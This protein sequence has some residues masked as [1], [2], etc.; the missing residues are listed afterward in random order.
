MDYDYAVNDYYGNEQTRQ[1]HV[2]PGK[3]VGHWTA[4]MADGAMQSVTYEAND[5]GYQANV[6]ISK[7][8]YSASANSAPVQAYSAPVKNYA[9]PAYA[10]T[11]YSAPSYSSPSY[12]APS[13][14][15]PSYIAPS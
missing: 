10:A 11:S 8:D 3:Q 5:Y 15:T 12:S 14:T 6:V 7:D 1:E 2:E 9:A 13:Y 4:R